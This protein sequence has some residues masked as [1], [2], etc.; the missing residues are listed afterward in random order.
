MRLQGDAVH[1][2]CTQCP[3]SPW[4]MVVAPLPQMKRPA[5]FPVTLTELSSL[6]SNL[7][8]CWFGSALQIELG[9]HSLLLLT[10]LRR[11]ALQPEVPIEVS[12]PGL[13]GNE[14]PLLKG[15]S[16]SSNFERNMRQ[17]IAQR[18]RGESCG[19]SRNVE[20]RARGLYPIG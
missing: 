4:H 10:L 20:Q 17:L 18:G 13:A 7:S 16:V 15:K 3:L 8:V 2:H 14:C 6:Q 12:I 5:Q 1:V 19:L 11:V 9:Q